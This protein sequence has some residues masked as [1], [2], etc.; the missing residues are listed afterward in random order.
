M[1]RTFRSGVVAAFVAIA[2]CAIS[3]YS[4]GFVGVRLL[5]NTVI[6]MGGASNPAGLNMERELNGYASGAAGTPYAGY[7]FR[8]VPWSASFLSLGFG[9]L[10]YDLSQAEGL[11]AL[12]TAIAGLEIGSKAVV[13]GY[14]ASADVVAKELRALQGRRDQGL[15]APSSSDLSFVTI[16]NP[17]RP[18]GGIM[19]RVQGAFIP[20]PFGATF[21][22]SM[23]ETDYHVLD[24]SWEYD[25]VSDFP[26]HPFNILA[27][28]NAAVA[29][30]TR[31]SFYFDADPTDL[32]A[33]IAD[34]TVGNT[35]YLTL[36]REHLPLLEPLYE[37]KVLDSILDL[38]E[39]AL[40]YVVDLAYDRTTNPGVPTPMQWAP[41]KRDPGKVLEGFVKALGGQDSPVPPPLA[42]T[43]PAATTPDVLA[44]RNRA[45]L[46]APDDKP[47]AAP[48]ETGA[49]AAKTEQAG[50][51]IGRV[52][53][54]PNRLTHESAHAAPEAA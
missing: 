10:A 42:A 27:D 40:R 30:L 39:P 19:S 22:G 1:G 32:N 4:P 36:K 2:I 18:N 41:I 46:S 44:F 26:A 51:S 13:M 49:K 54:K 21:G 23:P 20:L 11:R 38:V 7:E 16:G 14:S 29:F 28:L 12:D 31:H 9:G 34:F 47:A 25:P 8:T 6:A 5:A 48:L 45:V 24:V 3:I 50:R 37:L 35:R 52:G 53:G 33:V 15:S 17:T 43:T